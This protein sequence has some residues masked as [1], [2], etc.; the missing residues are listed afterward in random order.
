MLSERQQLDCVAAAH[1]VRTVAWIDEGC[2]LGKCSGY[3]EL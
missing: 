1:I 3:T 2:M